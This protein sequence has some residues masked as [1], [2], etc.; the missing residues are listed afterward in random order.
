M[1]KGTTII[2]RLE[3]LSLFVCTYLL[4]TD[5]SK[6]NFQIFRPVFTSP[7]WYTSTIAPYLVNFRCYLACFL[8]QPHLCG[9]VTSHYDFNLYSKWV[10][11]LTNFWHVRWM[12]SFVKFLFMFCAPFGIELHFLYGSVEIYVHIFWIWVLPGMCTANFMHSVAYSFIFYT[13]CLLR[14][15]R[16]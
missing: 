14:D 11:K 16:L 3:L 5:A 6:L 15:R 2:V 7:I 4:L 10:T 8:N 9:P 1:N 13:W 12:S